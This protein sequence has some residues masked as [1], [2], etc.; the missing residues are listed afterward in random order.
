MLPLKEE[1]YCPTPFW[2]YLGLKAVI[3]CSQVQSSMGA[4]RHKD[5]FDDFHSGNLSAYL[6]V[7][8]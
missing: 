2:K 1:Q 5:S 6:C 7:Y 4:G 3:S 8:A